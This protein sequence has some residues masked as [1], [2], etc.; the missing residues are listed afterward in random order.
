MRSRSLLITIV[1]LVALFAAGCSEEAVSPRN[2]SP[3]PPELPP[4]ESMDFDFHFF[5]DGSFAIDDPTG[6][7]AA[8]NPEGR[9]N[10]LNAVIR[11][12]AMNIIIADAF[13]P[14]MTAF[15]A[16]IHTTP[17]IDEDGWFIWTY[18]WAAGPGHTVTLRLRGRVEGVTV[19]WRMGVEDNLADPPMDDFEW[20]WGQS[21]LV[22]DRGFWIFNG[23]E[24]NQL[25]EVARVDWE[26][27]AR[28][29][30][31]L[32]FRCIHEGAPEYDDRVTYGVDGRR[33][34]VRFYDASEDL[35]SEILWDVPSG[36]GSI[37]VP[38]YNGG[39][40]ACWD[41]HQFDVVCPDPAL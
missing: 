18:A 28:T 20:F 24:E 37:R 25:I 29:D 23:F 6:A 10:W 39:E 30:R 38:D 19:T 41:E 21:G 16:A 8:A 31:D 2:D 22:E 13:G 4:T 15:G 26:V 33:H 1:A 40:R 14:A 7:Q 9:L 3:Q 12:T 32:T 5:T 27:R 36:T 34:S 35:E 17:V 11:V